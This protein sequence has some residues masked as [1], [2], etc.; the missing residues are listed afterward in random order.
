M[1]HGIVEQMR[2]FYMHSQCVQNHTWRWG[3]LVLLLIGTMLAY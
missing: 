1:K 2:R 3:I